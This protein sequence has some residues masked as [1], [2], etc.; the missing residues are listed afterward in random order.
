MD[1]GG[2][3][4]VNLAKGR[5]GEDTASLLGALL[6]SRINLAALSRAELP[7]TSRR[8]FFCFLD[9]FQNFA[10]LSFL[11]ML[12]ELRKYGV[13]MTLAHQYLDQL[14]LPI[15]NAV[16]GN[17][18]TLVSFRLGAEDAESLAREFYPYFA[19]TD[20]VN[21]PNHHIYLKLMIDGVPSRPFS[22]QTLKP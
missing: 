21:L 4:L 5:I 3:L 12:S 15:K 7:E 22:A 9:E 16:L 20:L 13:G 10:S 6:L 18:G 14:E 8:P 17:T 11:S 19:A 1:S 2:I